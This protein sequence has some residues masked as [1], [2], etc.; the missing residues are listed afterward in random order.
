MME[1]R[2]KDIPGYEGYY[3][4]SDQG[5]I[6]GLARYVNLVTPNGVQTTRRIAEAYRCPNIRSHG[7]YSIVLS[8]ERAQ[9]QFLVHRLVAAVFVDGYAPNKEVNH[10]NG[11]KLDNKAVNLEWVTSVEN[12]LHAAKTGLIK[13]SKSIIST[14]LQTGQQEFF[15]SAGEAAYKVSGNRKLMPNVTRAIKTEGVYKNRRWSYA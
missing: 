7:Y 2:W 3:Q 5:R 9:K 12:S 15:Y 4:V 11:C 10:K 13:N 1:E 8:F 6:K 14:D